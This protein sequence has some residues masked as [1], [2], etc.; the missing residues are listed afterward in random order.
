MENKCCVK[1]R[2]FGIVC[3]DQCY[4]PCWCSW[5]EKSS[6][7]VYLMCLYSNDNQVCLIVYGLNFTAIFGYYCEKRT[8]NNSDGFPRHD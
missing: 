7:F 8:Y 3:F 5:C 2:R 1:S 6:E 4:F